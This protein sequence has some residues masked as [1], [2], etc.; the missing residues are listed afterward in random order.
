[1]PFL[2]SAAFSSRRVVFSESPPAAGPLETILVKNM[3][4]QRNTLANSRANAVLARAETDISRKL[5]YLAAAIEELA[6][7][8]DQ[9]DEAAS[10]PRLPPRLFDVR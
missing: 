9:S 5:D 6:N 8:L 2:E 7:A 4:A 1:M 3:I 10:D